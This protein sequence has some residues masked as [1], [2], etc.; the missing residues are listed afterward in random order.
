MVIA[1]KE[2]LLVSIV[3]TNSLVKFDTSGKTWVDVYV[4][5]MY[6]IKYMSSDFIVLFVIIIKLIVLKV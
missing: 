5:E 1:E 3:Y 6:L 2:S 4:A